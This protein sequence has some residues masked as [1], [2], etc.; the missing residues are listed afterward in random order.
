MQDT[1]IQKKWQDLQKV[2]KNK[3][4]IAIACSG[5]LDSRLLAYAVKC[6]EVP[7]KILHVEGLHIPKEEENILQKFA[8]T[9]DIE[10][11]SIGINPLE[12]ANIK[13]NPVDRCYFCKKEIF[14][15]LKELSADYLLCDGSNTDDL[16]VYRPG[17]KAL[18]E[19]EIFSPY[20]EASISK[21]DI[22]NIAEFVA[23][24]FK[25]QAPQACLLTRFNYNIELD[26]HAI[27]WL[28]YAENCL[29][30]LISSPFRL[31]STAKDVYELHIEANKDAY[32]KNYA[33]IE[34]KLENLAKDNLKIKSK[35]HILFFDSLRSYFDKKLDISKEM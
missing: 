34:A 24:P 18:K 26:A 22:R 13:E 19:L 29:K 31:R 15:L 3:D 32:A 14:S 9:I 7:Y 1:I 20:L 16:Q 25:D 12:I 35:I 30:Q 5:G 4:K 21:E 6:A 10:I 28:D 23:L 11:N 2:L 8:H 17:N 33:E 27:L